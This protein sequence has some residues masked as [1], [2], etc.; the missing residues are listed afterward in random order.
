MALL[1]LVLYADSFAMNSAVE[2]HQHVD[3]GMVG[4]ECVCVS[5]GGSEGGSFNR[6]DGC[7]IG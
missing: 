7:S 2:H 1:P 3:E 6:K 5:E 4:S